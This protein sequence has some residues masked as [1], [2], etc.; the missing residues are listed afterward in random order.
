MSVFYFSPTPGKWG[1]VWAIGRQRGSR[2]HQLRTYPLLLSFFLSLAL[3]SKFPGQKEKSPSYATELLFTRACGRAMYCIVLYCIAVPRC[4]AFRESS[5]VKTKINQ[6]N[7]T[8]NPLL[9]L[10][11]FS[12]SFSLSLSLSLSLLN[13]RQSDAKKKLKKN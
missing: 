12:F 13:A 10:F 4:A 5:Y 2:L 3:S 7:N 9:S 1:G 6:S 11:F 8:L